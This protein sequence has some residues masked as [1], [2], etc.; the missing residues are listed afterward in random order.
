MNVKNCF[1]KTLFVF[2]G[3]SLMAGGFLL[4]KPEGVNA[5]SKEEPKKF[6]SWVLNCST[7]AQKKQTCLLTQ[8]INNNIKDK[9]Q[10]ILAIYNIGYFG[11]EKDLKIVEVVPANIQVAPGTS[12]VSG[13]KLIAPGKY[14]TCTAG[15]CQAVATISQ[16][17]LKTILANDNNSIALM[18][19]EGKQINFPLSK[20]GLEEGVKALKK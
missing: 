13:T 7:D 12:I 1:K 15:S 10:E 8:Q 6:G 3:L 18:N 4:G 20:D 14:V 2:A 11:Q 16:S 5:A 19:I 17:D 9:E